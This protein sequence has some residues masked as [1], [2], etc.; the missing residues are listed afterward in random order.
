ML[1]VFP[2]NFLSPSKLNSYR[3]IIGSLRI[4][5][6]HFQTLSDQFPKSK[7]LYKMKNKV[8][9]FKL[10]LNWNLLKTISQIDRFD[11]SWSSIEKREGSNLKQ[12]KSIA[13]IQS[14]GSSTR[15]E[16]SKMSDME[17]E[18]LLNDM[19]ISKL[20]NRDAQ[21]VAGYSTVLNTISSSF[22]HI[23]VTE[24]NIKNLHNQLLKYSDKDKWHRGNYKQHINAVEAT[25]PD[26]TRQIIFK[27]AEPGFPTEDAMRNLI[28]WYDN[29]KEIHP[30]IITA[31]LIY[32]FLSVHPFQDGNGRLS[33]LLTNL[34]LMKYGYNWIEYIS[35]EHE[36]EKNKKDYYRSLRICQ[37]QRP[38][39]DITEW[40]NFFLKSLSNLQR[41][42]KEKLERTGILTELSLQ[43]E[44]I[45]NFIINNAGTQVGVISKKLDINISSV[46]RTISKLLAM[47]LI[48]KNG[49]GRGTNYKIK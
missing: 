39:E 12:L 37:S 18:K 3:F 22:D 20:E 15:I 5:T 6:A 49:I 4:L 23:E 24:S 41:K 1:Y 17:V 11:A 29:E 32:D 16:G 27:T 33:R 25:F 48:Q 36:I 42:L 13:T 21:E 34:L 10:E 44:K 31:S 38:N 7:Y 35:F 26:G 30:L 9:N 14:V 46:K 2:T 47:N 19:D 40:I 45:Y 43:Q 28:S 8:Y